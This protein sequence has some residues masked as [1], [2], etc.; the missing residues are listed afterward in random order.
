MT[1]TALKNRADPALR[2]G[3][4]EDS[5]DSLIESIVG[6]E[7]REIVAE[8]AEGRAD[9]RVL[10]VGEQ[11]ENRPAGTRT[12]EYQICASTPARLRELVD[13][14]EPSPAFGLGGGGLRGGGAQSA[15]AARAVA[16]PQLA[17][18]VVGGREPEAV[19][20]AGLAQD[21]AADAGE[22]AAAAALSTTFS[23]VPALRLT[24]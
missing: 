20:D 9:V 23:T 11:A 21:A 2:S 4:L 1:L 19:E 12:V 24:Q 16:A 6:I 14:L 22:L 17:A 18:A 13:G 7:L 15:V 8:V 3:S 5:R 10:S